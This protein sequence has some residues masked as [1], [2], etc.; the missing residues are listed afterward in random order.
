MKYQ[1]IDI[2]A[3]HNLQIINVFLQKILILTISIFRLL[4]YME[5]S[6]Y[7]YHSHIEVYVFEITA[8]SR[9]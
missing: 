7:K 9:K 8:Y 4:K 3:I 6:N 5:V 1:T 2:N